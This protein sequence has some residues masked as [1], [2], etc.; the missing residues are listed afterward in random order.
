MGTRMLTTIKNSIFFYGVWKKLRLGFT[1]LV[2]FVR[3]HS[4]AKPVQT[5]PKHHSLPRLHRNKANTTV[6][7][8]LIGNKTLLGGLEKSI[9]VLLPCDLFLLLSGPLSLAR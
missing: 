6:K 3:D 4:L 5:F 7:L 1:D 9:Q 2:F 8:L